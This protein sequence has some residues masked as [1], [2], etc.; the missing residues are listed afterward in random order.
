MILL[1]T[2][3][4]GV[5]LDQLCGMFHLPVLSHLPLGPN[6]AVCLPFE[7]VKECSRAS[8]YRRRSYEGEN[9]PSEA[10]LHEGKGDDFH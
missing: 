4:S 6:D 3:G 9:F 5:E 2:L 1:L 7:G 10:A 8:G